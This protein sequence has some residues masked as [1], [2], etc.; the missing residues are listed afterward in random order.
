V[1]RAR[2]GSWYNEHA[3]RQAFVEERRK[4]FY[5]LD[6]SERKVTGVNW[7]FEKASW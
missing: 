3:Y 6:Y 2:G 4:A 7:E 5:D 1:E